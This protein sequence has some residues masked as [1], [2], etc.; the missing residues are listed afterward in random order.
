MAL[1]LFQELARCTVPCACTETS[2]PCAR[3]VLQ[4]ELSKSGSSGDALPCARRVRPAACMLYPGKKLCVGMAVHAEGAP[5]TVWLMQHHLLWRVRQ[6]EWQT[7]EEPINSVCLGGDLGCAQSIP[8]GSIS[9]LEIPTPVEELY[10]TL[11]MGCT[12]IPPSI[13]LSGRGRLHGQSRIGRSSLV[14]GTA[15]HEAPSPAPEAVFG[16]VGREGIAA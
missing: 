6:G 2:E 15:A 10:D 8:A 13:C 14:S 12:L 7:F 9:V 11:R 16:V 3:A 4:G 5:S 1:Q